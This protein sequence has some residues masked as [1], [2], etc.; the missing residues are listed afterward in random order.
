MA[1]PIKDLRG[2]RGKG[3]DFRTQPE[4][5]GGAAAP[6][7]G[8]DAVVQRLSEAAMDAF[9]GKAETESADPGQKK[10]PG[11]S[12]SR[13]GTTQ[14][15]NI[16]SV[17]PGPS[18]FRSDA[19]AD[20]ATGARGKVDAGA[21]GS[22]SAGD[23][24]TAGTDAPGGELDQGEAGSSETLDAL[25]LLQKGLQQPEALGD[26]PDAAAK[27]NAAKPAEGVA[28]PKSEGSALRTQ[29]EKTI[30][31]N[32][33]LEK[34]LKE[35]ESRE[36]PRVKEVTTA[37]ESEK[38][39]RE[40][41]EARIA[42]LDYSQ[43]AEFKE[44]FVAPYE[45]AAKDTLHQLRGMTADDG[46]KLTQQELETIMVGGEEAAYQL[47][48]SKFSGAKATMATGWV[49][50]IYSLD[51]VRY[52]ALES[53]KSMAVERQK[54]T[55]AQSKARQEQIRMLWEKERDG[56]M[57]AAKDLFERPPGD[58]TRARLLDEGAILADAAFFRPK[59]VSDEQAIAIMA[60]VRNRATALP[61]V[62][63]DRD[64]WKAKAEAYEARL[65]KYEGHAPGN[66]EPGEDA[67]VRTSKH[68]PG[69]MEF[70]I[71]QLRELAS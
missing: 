25:A 4:A 33:D 58:K 67:G 38:K 68:E 20:G 34:R 1:T 52:R 47:I 51:R 46:T 43:S 44:R 30:A 26:K 66:G 41:A 29:L 21:K 35:L 27:D 63:A 64:S 16:G 10:N 56:R 5:R 28:K 12:Q 39:A 69:T 13:G 54:Q 8:D 50:D 53:A 3:L 60:E 19:I 14:N 17:D 15:G 45:S 31:Q 59:N 11:E 48:D 9:G 18:T 6:T 70:A 55:Q 71:D 24:D 61:A 49:K 7:G 42:H 36:D 40:E 23:A 2:S 32:R 62:K 57:A 65:R 37:W 22:A